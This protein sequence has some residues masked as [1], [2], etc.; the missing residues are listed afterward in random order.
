MDWDPVGGRWYGPAALSYEPRPFVLS[1]L[2]TAALMPAAG[3]GVVVGM[4][5]F[6]RSWWDVNAGVF[7]VFKGLVMM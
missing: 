7:G 3:V 5:V 1:I 6:V 4:Q 2:W